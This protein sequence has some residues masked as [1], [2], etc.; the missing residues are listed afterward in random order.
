MGYE[1]HRN[2]DQYREWSTIVD[3]YTTAP[4]TR[5]EMA[6]YLAETTDSRREAAPDRIEA[7]LA[8]VDATRHLLVRPRDATRWDTEICDGCGRF[9][10]AFVPQHGDAICANCGMSQNDVAHRPQCGTAE[11]GD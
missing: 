10:H 5:A 1:I 4:M 9:H 3:K 6:Q 8:R 2:G 11:A 7:R